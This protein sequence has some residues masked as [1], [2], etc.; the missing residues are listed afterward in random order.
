MVLFIKNFICF[1]FLAFTQEVTLDG[2]FATITDETLWL[3]ECS[4]ALAPASC[5]LIRSVRS[6][7]IIVEVAADSQDALDNAIESVSENGLTLPTFGN[8]AKTGKLLVRLT[9]F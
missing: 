9:V 5:M 4:T 2:N 6:Y 1:L 7:S 8:Y 3:S